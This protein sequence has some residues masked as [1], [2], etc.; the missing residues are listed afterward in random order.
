MKSGREANL[1][2]AGAF[3]LDG[4]LFHLYGEILPALAGFAR[5]VHQRADYVV[6]VHV[7]RTREVAYLRHCQQSRV[8]RRAGRR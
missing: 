6:D 8:Q 5:V 4:L 7:G 3:S 2:P 1:A